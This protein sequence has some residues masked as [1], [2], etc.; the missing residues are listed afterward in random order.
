VRAAVAYRGFARRALIR[1]KLQ[2]RREVLEPLAAQFAAAVAG[3][4]SAVPEALVI[5]VPS[6][7]WT[8]WRRGFDPAAVFAKAAALGTDAAVVHGVLGRRWASRPSFKRLGAAGR[9]RAAQ[10]AFYCRRPAVVAGRRVMLVDDVWTT[11]ASALACARALLAAG[12]V[13]VHV[14][15]WART[16]RRAGGGARDRPV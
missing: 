10:R 15:V 1:A 11:G 14:A 8:R 2:G 5:P 12:A 9:R 6:H 13:T 7:P 16:P 3:W 4:E